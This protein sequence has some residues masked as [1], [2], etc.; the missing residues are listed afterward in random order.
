M[1]P[2]VLPGEEISVDYTTYKL[3]SPSRW[4]VV[5]FS[6][7]AYGAKGPLWIMRIVGLPGETIGFQSGGI[8]VNG[9]PLDLPPRL[10]YISYVSLDAMKPLHAPLPSPYVVPADSYFVLGDNSLH[11]NDS[12]MWGAVPRKNIAGKVPGK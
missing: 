4:D 7:P 3:V 12:R 9:R 5:A 10:R 8:T 1:S 2:T 6:P 11:A